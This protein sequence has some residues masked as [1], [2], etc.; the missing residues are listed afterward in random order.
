MPG[1][2]RIKKSF[3][4]FCILFKAIIS[5][6]QSES[7]EFDRYTIN[8]GLS[9]GYVN[10]IFQDSKGFMWF[11]TGNG[12]N[13][14][15]GLSFKTFYYDLK[16]ST[17]IPGNDVN[18]M[19]EDSLGR[20]WII[21]NTGIAYF[22]LK[23]DLFSRTKL[24]V[25][26]KIDEK[27]DGNAC[28]LDSKGFLWIGSSTGILRIAVY[29][30][31]S[32]RS[33]FLNA[34]K[35]LLEEDD[36][37][38]VNQNTF[39][40]FVE[41]ENGKVWAAS[42]SNRLYCFNESQH[43]F[44]PVPINHPDSRNFSNKQ[45]G[46]FKDSEGN[47]LLSIDKAGFLICDRHKGIFTLYAPSGND[48]G[49]IGNILYALAD[50]RK[51]SIW[52]GDRYSEGISIFN[53]KTKKFTYC[54][55]DELNPY[56]LISDKIT[57]IYTDKEG[58]VWVGTILGVCKYTPGKVKFSRFFSNPNVPGKLNYN[59]TLCFEEDKFSNIWIGT[60][61]G[62]LYKMDPKTGVFN[63]YRHTNSDPVSI[64]SNAI[65]SLCEDHEGTLWIGT[66][67]GGLCMMKNGIFHT[68][69]PDLSNINS[70]SS[71]DIWYVFEDSRQ[72]LWIATLTNGLDLLD[73][74]TGKFYHYSHNDN[75]STSI[76]NNSL[77][78]IYEDSKHKL[79]FTSYHGVSTFDLNSNDFSKLPHQIKFS[80]LLHQNGK[81]G[82]STNAVFCAK[83][84]NKGNIWFG[85]MGSGLDKL[86]PVTGRFT[87]YSIR[88]GLPGNFIHSILVDKLNNLWLA[89]DK[90]L[91]M[92][93]SENN[94]IN[95]YDI[96]DGLL[97]KSLKS[98]ALK[99][100]KGEMFFGGADGFNSFYPEK[101]RQS[102]NQK[103]PEVVFTGLK[104][105]N[106]PV[107]I[108]EKI[109]SRI[110]LKSSIS[111]TR[112]LEL[113]YK[114]NFFA[115]E[116]IAL[117]F[118]NPEK[119]NY[120]YKMDGFN[121][122]WIMSGTNHEA[123]Y[124]NL[125]P[126]DY[127]FRVKASNSDGIWN[128]KGASIEINILPPWWKTLWF[129]IITVFS[130]LILFTL[131]LIVRERSLKS[132]KIL[133]EQTVKIKTFELN[134]L[135]AS[136]DKFF[137]IIAHDLKNPF[138]TII[139]LSDLM[140]EPGNL[141][142]P[143]QLRKYSSLINASAVQ[144]FRLLENLLE[145]ANSQRGKIQF[146]PVPVN[147]NEIIKE[148]FSLVG[149]MASGKNIRLISYI[150]D[151]LTVI[152]DKNMLRTILR[153][154]ITNGVKFTENSG[155][156]R[157]NSLILDK[158]VEISVTDNGIGISEDTISKLFR[159][160]GDLSTYGTN[161]ERGTGLGLFLCKEFVEKHGGKIWC[162]SKKGAGSVFRFLLPADKSN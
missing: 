79:Y 127:T 147:I 131:I 39:S 37:E 34:E 102:R 28:L 108:N 135:N 144:T 107:F 21:T 145:W 92:F 23:R 41:D 90:G 111:E 81:S 153:N 161:N 76:C 11:G 105:F 1:K 36:V 18:Q 43:A 109:N 27:V 148:E 68:F 155:E 65:I 146:L 142:S 70:I 26:G 82:I 124:T 33:K 87:N 61:G 29:N 73:R 24:I 104:I 12:L 129:R 103:V 139:G 66:Y 84:D 80:N 72:N 48:N 13:R 89:T 52:V 110:I 88:E 140:Q 123:S 141:E 19:V 94:E 50:D 95:V 7:I 159:I 120:A 51:G 85:T 58:S 2:V 17:S 113:T 55:S 54:R 69:M 10:S 78:S 6:G 160:D 114:E 152:A 62:G 134:E 130:V 44:I 149:E 9:N 14:F 128:E 60:D 116:F 35:F 119:N 115:L 143:D 99:T 74:K 106:K 45:K 20:I 112:K 47:F 42:Y 40:S 121:D 93:N 133:L 71:T 132:Q 77:V 151:P 122:E 56:S 38:S 158:T 59:N 97:N 46:F 150:N 138:N 57:S 125:D 96:K 118:T 137:S 16:D 101:I 126:G 31:T 5:F 83:E 162:E 64:S 117:E 136:K 156:V 67:A 91:T 53:K 75:D 63:H 32:V 30:N 49:P 8:D 4:C 25:N 86:D 15:N 98:W 154:L 100:R 157:I 3:L 22:D